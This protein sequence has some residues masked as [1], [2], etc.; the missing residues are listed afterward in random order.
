MLRTSFSQ[1][2]FKRSVT[3]KAHFSGQERNRHTLTHTQRHKHTKKHL[4]HTH[5]HKRTLTLVLT[6]TH[7]ITRRHTHITN[8]QTNNTHPKTHIHT[9]CLS[10]THTHN[11]K[12]TNKQR[13]WF[14]AQNMST[15]RLTRVFWK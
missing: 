3:L 10:Q 14:L 15:K 12:Q 1:D 8:K 4:T 6:Y 11:N 7:F 9:L 5:T 13:K 2:L